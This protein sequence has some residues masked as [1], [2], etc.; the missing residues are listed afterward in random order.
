MV[1]TA[2][3]GYSPIAFVI[4]SNVD[5]T[6]YANYSFG[7]DLFNDKD[8]DTGLRDVAVVFLQ[9]GNPQV[10]HRPYQLQTQVETIDLPSRKLVSLKLQGGYGKRIERGCWTATVLASEGTFPQAGYTRRKSRN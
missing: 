3:G 8:V 1:N 10:T 7:V 5:N 6:M 2:G 4:P 9:G